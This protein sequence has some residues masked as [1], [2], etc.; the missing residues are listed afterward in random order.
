MVQ[1]CMPSPLLNTMLEMELGTGEDLK[2][3]KQSKYELIEQEDE[4]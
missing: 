4:N 1:V 3:S 2:Q